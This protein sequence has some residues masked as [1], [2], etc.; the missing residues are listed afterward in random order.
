M[1]GQAEAE[2]TVTGTGTNEHGDD[3]DI[4]SNLTSPSQHIKAQMPA[5]KTIK[6]KTISQ[7]CQ[8]DAKSRQGHPSS[9]N[10][11]PQSHF[12]T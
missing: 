12:N 11:L 6:T 5:V 7:V 4:D 10:M 9:A 3:N 2:I 8:Q 1:D